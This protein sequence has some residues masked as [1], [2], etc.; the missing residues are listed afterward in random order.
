MSDDPQNV[1]V[2][3]ASLAGMR[4]VQ[5]AREVGYTGRLTLIGE[6]VHHPYDRPPLSKEYLAEGDLTTIHEFPDAADLAESADVDLRTGTRATSVDLDAGIVSTTAG[7]VEFDALLIATGVRARRAQHTSM[8]Y[9]YYET[10]TTHATS[11]P[12]WMP[13]PTW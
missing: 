2:V 4:A 9:T 8:E 3:G 13:A 10:W 12:P 1:V 11:E 7:T 6:E 5:T